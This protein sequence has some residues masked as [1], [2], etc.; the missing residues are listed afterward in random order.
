MRR[1]LGV[2]QQPRKEATRCV[3]TSTACFIL[4]RLKPLMQAKQCEKP[5]Q[6]ERGGRMSAGCSGNQGQVRIKPAFHPVQCGAVD[7]NLGQHP[8]TKAGVN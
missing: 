5:K 4:A 6:N 2:N 1:L 3:Q 8:A 7:C